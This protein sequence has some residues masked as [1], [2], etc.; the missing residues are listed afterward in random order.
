M[1]CQS[2]EAAYIHE[3]F[4]PNRSPGW[5]TQPMPYWFMYV[6]PENEWPYLKPVERVLSFQYPIASL[7]SSRSLKDIAR[8]APEIL[9]AIPARARSRRPL[10]KDPFALFS[11][12]WLA[13][14]CRVRPVVMIR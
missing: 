12:E 2:R 3:P 1:L 8:Q 11:T 10:L 4:C 13:D 7:V 14:R 5:L 6:T 9:R